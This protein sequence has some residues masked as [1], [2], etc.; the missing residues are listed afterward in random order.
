MT[1]VEAAAAPLV[2]RIMGS[3]EARGIHVIIAGAG[4]AAHLPTGLEQSSAALPVGRA[5]T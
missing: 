2:A 1:K 3:A 4:G 5:W